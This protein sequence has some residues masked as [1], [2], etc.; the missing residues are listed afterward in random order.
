MLGYLRNGANTGSTAAIFHS[1]DSDL[2]KRGIISFASQATS[3]FFAIASILA[4][5]I[6]F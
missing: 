5:T 3:S 1:K 2:L 6:Y 4:K